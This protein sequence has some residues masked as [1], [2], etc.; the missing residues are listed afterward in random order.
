MALISESDGPHSLAKEGILLRC[1]GNTCPWPA[2]A[3][4]ILWPAKTSTPRKG[5]SHKRLHFAL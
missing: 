4:D 1:N 2:R 5:E 3:G